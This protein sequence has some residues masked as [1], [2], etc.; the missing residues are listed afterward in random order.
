MRRSPS[1]KGVSPELG[2]DAQRSVLPSD[3]L[4]S[5]ALAPILPHLS[6]FVT[7]LSLRCLQYALPADPGLWAEDGP[8][9]DD[10]LHN[11]D[12]KRDRKNDM[13][14][15]IFTWRGAENLGCL[16]ILGLGLFMLFA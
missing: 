5:P 1:N 9:P 15:N 12:P 7:S 16:L 8:E 3:A 11:P 10:Y 13:S 6:P 4:V 2:A 14:T